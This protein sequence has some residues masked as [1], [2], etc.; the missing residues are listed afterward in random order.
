MAHV[1]T[2]PLLCATTPLPLP[3]FN[4]V[5]NPS[6]IFHCC[7]PAFNTKPCI[8]WTQLCIKPTAVS[9]RLLNTF[10]LKHSYPPSQYTAACFGKKKNSKV[11]KSLA[12]GNFALCF[13]ASLWQEL[14]SCYKDT[15][16]VKS[17][18]FKLKNILTS[19][20]HQSNSVSSFPSSDK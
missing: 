20:F 15:L 4:H 13:A 9:K 8:F 2:P 6:V 1:L 10:Q 14:Y 17:E 19:I 7:A 16:L 5:Q 12:L 18:C 3:P 11:N